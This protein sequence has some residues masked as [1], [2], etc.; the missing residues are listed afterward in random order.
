MTRTLPLS[1]VKMKLS[2]LVDGV[3]ER[4]DEVV[5]TR[6]GKPAAV[7]VDV[8][9]HESWQ[10]TMDVKSNSELMREIR[11]GLASFKKKTK[12]KAYSLDELF[13]TSTHG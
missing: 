4:H 5:I 11:K 13:G 7:L 9:E 2:A 10:E 3:V 1:E 12:S 6:N 8:V